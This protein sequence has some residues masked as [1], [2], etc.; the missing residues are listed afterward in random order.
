MQLSLF[1]WNDLQPI[2]MPKDKE[3]TAVE[4]FAGAGGLSIGL[5]RA[6]LHVVIANEIMTDFAATLMENHRTT[7]VI[8]EDIHKINFKRELEKLGLKSVDDLRVKAFLL[9]DQKTAKT[10][11]IHFS[12][13]ICV[14]SQKRILNTRSLKMYL[15]S[16]EC[17][18]VLHMKH[19]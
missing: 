4:L 3:F 6:G 18:M 10:H 15:A 2:H 9:L 7:N 19:L 17:I 8:N 12:M 11:A 13:N 14:Q 16:K 1:A 5:E